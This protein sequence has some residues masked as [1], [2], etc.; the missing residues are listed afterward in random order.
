M[1][2]IPQTTC[3]AMSTCT[4]NVLLVHVTVRKWRHRHP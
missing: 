3:I 4:D 2:K 1:N